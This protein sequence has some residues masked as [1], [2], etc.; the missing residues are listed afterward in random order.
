MKRRTLCDADEFR[1]EPA[2]G[3]LFAER[4]GQGACPTVPMTEMEAHA[5]DLLRTARRDRPLPLSL[6]RCHLGVSERVAKGVIESLI[7][8][9]GMKIGASREEPHGYYVI[10]SIEDQEAAVGPYRAQILAMLRRL[11]VLESPGAV[12]EWLGQLQIEL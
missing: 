4:T 8:D 1:F 9:H 7:V 6:L 5:A 12:R 10:E 11:R 2:A 3:P